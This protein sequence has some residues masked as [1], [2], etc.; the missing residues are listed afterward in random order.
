MGAMKNQIKHFISAYFVLGLIFSITAQHHLKF[1]LVK[2][3]NPN[4]W[5]G[6]S[7]FKEMNGL[8]YFVADDG[9]HGGELWVTDGSESGTQM[10]YD[11][12][13]NGGANI[14]G[15]FV[16]QN[17]LFFTADDG[18]HG[19]ELWVSDGTQNGT[20]LVKDI[21]TG[22]MPTPYTFE[23]NSSILFN[24]GIYKDELYFT[25]NDGIHGK[26]MW[27][28]DGTAHGTKMLKDINPTGVSFNDFNPPYIE[29]GTVYK[30]RMYFTATDSIHGYELWSTD[31]TAAGTYMLKDIDPNGD[32]Y[33]VTF[34][35]FRGLLFFNAADSNGRE[36]WVTDGTSQGTHLFAD[37]V[38]SGV[39]GDPSSNPHGFLEFGNAL[40]FVGQPSTSFL[41]KLYRTNGV[42]VKEVL[43]EPDVTWSVF[44]NYRSIVFNNKLYFN[45]LTEDYGAE[46][47]VSDGTFSGTKL[48][49]DIDTARLSV[50]G[51]TLSS[52]PGHFFVFNDYLFFKA[53]D[54]KG[55]GRQ[56]WFT[57]KTHDFV[58]YIKGKDQVPYNG[59]NGFITTDQIVIGDYCYFMGNYDG[60]GT[61]LWRMYDSTK[62]N[63]VE[64]LETEN[65][66]QVELYP[67]PSGN[68]FVNL[69][70]QLNQSG[71]VQ[72]QL[73][74]VSGRWA[75]SV[76][77][78]N[79]IQGT[80]QI[81][82][83]LDH[84]PEGIYLIEIQ[85]PQGKQTVKFIRTR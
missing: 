3:I 10:V 29:G 65:L 26:E 48:V 64:E 16:M 83:P 8:I 73:F 78:E 74:D 60:Y 31:G 36:L 51:G 37:I 59:A 46:L 54:S 23:N 41:Q 33:P 56:L 72:V 71:N 2:D 24:A 52:S 68:S 12:N 45:G 14:I 49:A 69:K 47:W 40:Y 34:H 30:N 22:T 17:K 67:N 39:V 76:I 84:I 80:H 63:G 5:S 82:I 43:L 32:G 11:I 15:L 4:G 81:Q 58:D 62:V 42:T 75:Q 79:Q 6:A 19:E 50:F 55:G 7:G 53:R 9:V 44:K 70:Y 25:A 18:I 28:T 35:E 77:H 27:K 66:H 85:T 61:E 21:N 20:Y 57:N 1:E 13:P 38:P